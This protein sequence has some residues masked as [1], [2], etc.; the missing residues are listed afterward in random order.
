MTK[1]K[2]ERVRYEQ[3]D[4]KKANAH[5]TVTNFSIE[6]AYDLC[7]PMLKNFYTFNFKHKLAQMHFV[8]HSDFST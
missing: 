3:K 5:Q 4:N 2:P 7:L 8:L 1:L 6:I